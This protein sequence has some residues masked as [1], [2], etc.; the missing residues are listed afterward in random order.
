MTYEQVAQ[1]IFKEAKKAGYI[2]EERKSIST[3]SVY[4]KLI[5]GTSSLLFRV[6]DHNTKSDVITLRI[7]LK[8]SNKTA[9]SFVKNRIRDLGYRALKMALG[10]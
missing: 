5:S 6:S 1:I 10:L 8:S 3:Q 2:V 9:E 7:D 4:Y